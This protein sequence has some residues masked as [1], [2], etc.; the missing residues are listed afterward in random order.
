MEL[1]S[2]SQVS[3]ALGISTRMLR[4][5]EQVGL[6]Q[7]VRN[8][9]NSYRYYDEVALKRVQQITILRKLQIPVKQIAIILNNPDAVTAIE[10]FNENIAAIQTEISALETIKSAL[11]IFVAKIE[12]LAAVRLNLNLLTDKAVIELAQSLSLTQKNVK[13]NKT[14]EDLNQASEIIEKTKGQS[15]RVAHYQTETAAKLCCENFRPNENEKIQ[16]EKFIRDAD[17]IKIKPDFRCL[18]F[19]GY[20]T[21]GCDFYVTI[22]DDLEVPAPFEKSIMPGGLYAAVT[23]T[24]QNK[25]DWGMIEA[26]LNNSDDYMNDQGAVNEHAIARPAHDVY[27][28]PLNIYGLKN[29]DEFNSVCNPDYM[30]FHVPIREKEKITDAKILELSELEELASRSN[31]VDI[32]LTS[33]VKN[34]DFSLTYTDNLMIMKSEADYHGGMAIPQTFHLPLKIELRAKTDS[35]DLCISCKPGL[36]NINAGDFGKPLVFFDPEKVFPYNTAK[37]PTNEFI[38]VEWILGR[39]LMA[40]K[41]NGELRELS[42]DAAYI[43]I[44]K[45]NPDAYSTSISITSARNATITVESLRVTEL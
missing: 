37:I 6:I 42:S 8:E 44:L 4:Y 28:N 43:Q 26:W 24:P 40:I 39:N 38:D 22:P 27:F 34:A 13:E 45:D 41:I 33:M 18:S 25:N 9:D 7:S 31:S 1:Q 12:E 14:M 30:E 2:I 29:T 16:I 20:N 36:L 11:E 32:D 3:K 19:G 35:T 5:Y 23:I 17:L 15:V 21:S 10:I